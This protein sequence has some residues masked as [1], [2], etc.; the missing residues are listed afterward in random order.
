MARDLNP[1]CKQCRREGQKL[2]LKGDRCLGVKCA[3][4]KRNYIP[5]THGP[6]QG[7]GN[8]LRTTDYG[9][10]FREKQRAKRIYRIMESQLFNYFVKASKT[11]GNSSLIMATLLE[12][13]LDNTIFRLGLATSRDEARQLVTHGHFLVNRKKNSIPSYQVKQGDVITMRQRSQALLADRIKAQAN[14]NLPSWLAFESGEQKGQIIGLPTEKDL[15]TGID[16][17]VIVGFYSK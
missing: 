1:K 10:Q 5:G 15:D 3:L 13:R 14:K 11:K 8:R 17:K 2:L 7:P 12:T 6:K 9:K 4:V 16:M